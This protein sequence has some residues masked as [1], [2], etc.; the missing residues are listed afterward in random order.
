MLLML[1]FRQL[2]LNGKFQTFDWFQKGIP[3]PPANL[4]REWRVYSP[5]DERI[6]ALCEGRP[7]DIA[8]NYGLLKNRG[9]PIDLVAGRHDRVVPPE[10]IKCVLNYL[11]LTLSNELFHIFCVYL[12]LYFR[13]HFRR[14]RQGGAEVSLTWMDLSHLD[15]PHGNSDEARTL[16]L[17]LLRAKG[18]KNESS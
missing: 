14:L 11:Y 10:N 1:H 12:F 3:H 2:W 7:V 13:E 9:P 6:K 17:K 16:V 5:D 4:H 15:L 8:E 18:T